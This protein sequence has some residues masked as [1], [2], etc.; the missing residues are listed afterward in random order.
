MTESA[1]TTE[2]IDL[3]KSR[4]AAGQRKYGTTLDRTDLTPEQ[5][6]MHG[7]EE[8]LDGAGYLVAL[9]ESITRE[10][11]GEIW[12]M[13]LCEYR[14]HCLHPGILYRFTVDPECESCLKALADSQ[15]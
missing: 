11:G 13:N 12:D 6:A 1:I 7:I 8:L 3:L 10:R 4:D 14:T 5:W 9:R 15:A 2:L